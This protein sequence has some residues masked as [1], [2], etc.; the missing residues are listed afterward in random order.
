[1]KNKVFLQYS[2]LKFKNKIK[3][4]ILSYFLDLLLFP[5][6]SFFM[7]NTY[8]LILDPQESTEN[9]IFLFQVF[10]SFH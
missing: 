8:I 5:D 1:M 10:T 4:R 6:L 2:R 3:F 7:K 9:Y